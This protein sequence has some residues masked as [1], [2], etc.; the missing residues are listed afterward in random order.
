MSNTRAVPVRPVLKLYQFAWGQNPHFVVAEDYAEAENL[1]EHAGYSAPDK[2]QRISSHVILP[3][4]H[5]PYEPPPIL[6]EDE[7][8]DGDVVNEMSGPSESFEEKL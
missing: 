8:P 2:I 3:G 6:P 1:I 4:E 7:L 5:R